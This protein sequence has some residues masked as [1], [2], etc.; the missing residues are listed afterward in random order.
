MCISV[1]VYQLV[2]LVQ[3]FGFFNWPTLLELLLVNPV[4]KSKFLLE[5]DFLHAD[6]VLSV[7]RQC[8]STKGTKRMKFL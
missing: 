8:P 3:I 5:K 7:N 6:A 4:P 1:S 2:S